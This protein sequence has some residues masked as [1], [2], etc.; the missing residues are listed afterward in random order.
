MNPSINPSPTLNLNQALWEKGDFTRLA[1]T[2]RRSAEAFV[3][4]LNVGPHFNVLDVGCGDGTTALPIAQRKA[5]VLGVDIARNLVE[6]GNRR[7]AAAGLPNAMIRQGD[8]CDLVSVPDA[9]FDL[10]VSMF[11]AMF[12]PRP[13]DVAHAMV[14]VAKPGARIV[15]GNW[16]PGDPTLVAQILRIATQYAPPPAGFVSPMLWG[17]REEVV[18]RFAAVGIPADR[19]ETR[20]DTYRFEFAGAPEG[21]LALFRD[22]YG[23]TMNAYAA[24]DAAGKADQLHRELTELFIAQNRSTDPAISVFDATFLRVTVSL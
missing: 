23:P 20:H 19:I 5:T 13:L 4:S 14:R 17:V 12:A 7:L 21:F 9:S 15:M 6:A 11:G 3:A 18:A 2:M 22:Y 10:V 16:I 1:Q 24:A 8:A